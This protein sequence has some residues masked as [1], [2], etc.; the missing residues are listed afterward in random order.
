V[1]QTFANKKLTI[2]PNVGLDEWNKLYIHEFFIQ[3]HPEFQKPMCI[4]ENFK[5]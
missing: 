1:V 4:S 2:K 5:F 3:D